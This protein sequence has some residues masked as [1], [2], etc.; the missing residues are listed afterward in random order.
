[1]GDQDEDPEGDESGPAGHAKLRGEGLALM[2]QMAAKRSAIGESFR[3]GDATLAGWEKGYRKRIDACQKVMSEDP[4]RLGVIA[5]AHR[6]ALGKL[7]KVQQA[8]GL[9][10]S[11]ALFKQ[12]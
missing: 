1:M 10:R 2:G 3:Q 4:S 7:G 12:K 8:R 5:H 6:D 9:L 11:H